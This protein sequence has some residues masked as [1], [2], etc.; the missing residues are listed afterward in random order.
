[1]KDNKTHVR[2]VAE[3]VK[4]NGHTEV[5]RK[6]LEVHECSDRELSRFAAPNQESKTILEDLK[7]KKL[8]CLSG[9]NLEGQ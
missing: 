3:V 5:S 2:W 6:R 4:S 1:M 8:Y 9:S 7:E